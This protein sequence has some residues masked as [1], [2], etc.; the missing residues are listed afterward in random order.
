MITYRQISKTE[1]EVVLDRKKVGAIYTVDGGFQYW[2]K[3][4]RSEGGEVFPTLHAC[5]QSLE[6][7]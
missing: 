5:K 1:I 7:Q 3:G 4:P 2:P 6:G